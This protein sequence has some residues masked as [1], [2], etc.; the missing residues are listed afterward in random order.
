MKTKITYYR[1][2]CIKNGSCLRFVPNLFSIK[3]EK[4]YIQNMQSKESDFF[5][6]EEFD[7]MTVKK[8]INAA[9]SCPVN[10]LMISNL[11]SGEELSS[12]KI[13]LDKD[14]VDIKAKYNDLEEFVM[15]KKGYFL[16]RVDIKTQLIEVA[17]CDKIN[18][19]KLRVFGKTPID[20]YQTIIKNNLISRF[21]HAAYLGR[22]LQKAYIA[23]KKNISYVQDDEL[24]L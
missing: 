4:L 23:L 8:L 13:R 11:D 5:L 16:I 2:K 18:Q 7:E 10:A 22:E 6:I 14:Y 19:I 9:M 15:D 24:F 17:F 20:I 21:D 3:D 1:S 12:S